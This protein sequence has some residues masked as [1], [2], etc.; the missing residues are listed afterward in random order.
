MVQHKTRNTLA[1]WTYLSSEYFELESTLFKNNWML[2]G[3]ISE[4]QQTGDYITFSAAVSYTHLTLP[5]IY[6]V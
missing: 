3:H 2:A 4:L 6:S 5:T 1:P